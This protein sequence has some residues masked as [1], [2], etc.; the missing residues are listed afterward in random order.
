MIT[1]FQANKKGDHV[2]YDNEKPIATKVIVSN[3]TLS[4]FRAYKGQSVGY[5]TKKYVAIIYEI[6]EENNIG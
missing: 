3:D 6:M 4:K 1:T 2:I 5:D